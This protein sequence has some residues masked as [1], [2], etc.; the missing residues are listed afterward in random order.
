MLNTCCT[1][2]CLHAII[3]SQIKVIL[4]LL[5]E[6]LYSNL[7]HFWL[8][9][10]NSWKWINHQSKC[11]KKE[12]TDLES[13]RASHDV[14]LHL[15]S[16]ETGFF[17]LWDVKADFCKSSQNVHLNHRRPLLNAYSF[18]Y[19]THQSSI[20]RC[21]LLWQCQALSCSCTFLTV[22]KLPLFIL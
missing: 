13:I 11:T 14:H 4:I 19:C 2:C 8:H 18:L 6:K 15:S 10:A 21:L 1:E 16:S 5:H 9:Y 17:L 12:D 7:K 3:M 20:N 22:W